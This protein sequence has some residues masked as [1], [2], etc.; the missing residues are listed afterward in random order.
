MLMAQGSFDKLFL[1]H[2]HSRTLLRLNFMKPSQSRVSRVARRAVSLR[3]RGLR[4]TSFAPSL[5]PIVICV[6]LQ[7]LFFGS[8]R[9]G[10]RAAILDRHCAKLLNQRSAIAVHVSSDQDALGDLTDCAQPGAQFSY[11]RRD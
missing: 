1:T 9:L 8:C 4:E 6:Q 7:Q 5:Q 11:G 3:A 10:R 2:T